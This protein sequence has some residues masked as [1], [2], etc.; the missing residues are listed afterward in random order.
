MELQFDGD[1]YW[2][3]HVVPDGPFFSKGV[4]HWDDSTRTKLALRDPKGK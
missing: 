3:Y 2:E 1:R 4:L